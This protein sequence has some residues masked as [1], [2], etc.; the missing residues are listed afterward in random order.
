[1]HLR[2]QHDY[3]L[4][5]F[6]YTYALTFLVAYNQEMFGNKYIRFVLTYLRCLR[7]ANYFSGDRSL[8]VTIF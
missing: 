6:F 2:I 5:I 8:Y 1:M 4:A 7:A 3:F